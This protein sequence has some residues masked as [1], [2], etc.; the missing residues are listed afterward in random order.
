M[1]VDGCFWHQCPEHGSMPVRNRDYWEPKLRRNVERDRRA[2]ADPC[3][4]TMGCRANV[5]ARRRGVRRRP[6]HR[7]RTDKGTR[8]TG[9]IA[10]KA[11]CRSTNAPRPGLTQAISTEK[12]EGATGLTVADA[13]KCDLSEACHADVTYLHAR[14]DK[15]QH[16]LTLRC[17]ADQRRHYRQSLSVSA[18]YC[19]SRVRVPG[20][21]LGSCF[22]LV[23]TSGRCARG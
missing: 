16:R 5:G 17:S 8:R 21:P 14:A 23:L 6:G 1:F 18:W 19:A 20:D 10:S 15:G 22:E 11:P 9:R 3:G 4:R 2:D 7:G 12:F 13:K